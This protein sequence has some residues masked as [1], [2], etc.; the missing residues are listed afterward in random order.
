[1]TQKAT[2]VL[3]VDEELIWGSFDHTLAPE[4]GRLNPDTRGIVKD[5]L[6]LLDE[7]SIPATWAVV[8]HLFLSR[9]PRGNDGRAHPHIRRPKFDW[10]P[11]DWYQHDPCSTRE[12]DPLWYGDDILDAIQAA[13]TPQDIGSHSFSH[14]LFGDPGCTAEAAADDLAACL[15][16]ARAR[17]ISLRSFVFPRNSE[18]HHGLLKESGFTSYRGIDPA[19]YEALPPWAKRPAHYLDQAAAI[20]PP[21]SHP[22]EARPGLWNIPGSM[23]LFPRN[24]I[25]R[26]IP[27]FSRLAKAKAGLNQAVQEGKIF[28]LWFHPFNLS[29]D[30]QG[31]LGVLR[32]LFIECARLRDAGLLDI[33]SMSGVADSLSRAQLREKPR[34]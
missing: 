14:L 16:A 30:R 23:V 20:A 24:G 25:R 27:Y 12:K 31:L 2:F 26:A 9:C 18:G 15:E 10:Y 28:H 8:G 3:S 21:V 1:M 6:R 13:E 32:D 17:G 7:F 19:W 33:L 29:Y 11:H 5:I 4:F 22:Y 34:A